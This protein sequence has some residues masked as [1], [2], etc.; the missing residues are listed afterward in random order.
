MVT[1]LA[2]F[3]EASG[4]WHAVNGNDRRQLF[5]RDG[6]VIVFENTWF[7]CQANWLYTFRPAVNQY[8][9][10][11]PEA[12]SYAQFW[13]PPQSPSPAPLAQVLDWTR[14]AAAADLPMV[15]AHMGALHDVYTQR[16]YIQHGE[17]LYGPIH[18][19][20]V[21]RRP[22]EYL[23]STA[24]GGQR[25][26]VSAFQLPDHALLQVDISGA[27]L[28]LLD[29]RNLDVAQREE[30]WSLPQVVI[31]RVLEASNKLPLTSGDDVRLVDRRIKEL[32]R[33]ASSEGP[34]ALRI[35]APT[36]LRAQRIIGDQE[37]ALQALDNL[38]STLIGLPALRPLVDAALAQEVEERSSEVDALLVRLRQQLEQVEAD[39]D[40][41]QARQEE[42][43]AHNERLQAETTRR[44]Q[45]LADFEDH[46]KE[47][48]EA[49]R[50]EPLHILAEL[51]VASALLPSAAAPPANVSTDRVS[52]PKQDAGR[53]VAWHAPA[54]IEML[55]SPEALRWQSVL[56]AQRGGVR[57]Q[58]VHAG[59]R[60]NYLGFLAEVRNVTRDSATFAA[61]ARPGAPA[62]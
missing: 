24:V 48:S 2:F 36:L 32:A 35:P 1:P 26:L 9:T 43:I 39:I 7:G 60:F 61:H 40:A 22:R 52:Q 45:E 27:P 55:A 11:S 19:D 31:K 3:D 62:D 23:H 46:M 58:D 16:I 59:L 29:D 44:E 25:L 6:K 15:L 10:L 8:S 54:Q 20:E 14:L 28:D 30:D 5:P 37:A 38:G 4:E 49:L 50:R 21:S 34:E 47:R 18:I 41:A 57:S 42:L 33:A 12:P 51:N 56:A 13:I 17:T 53:G